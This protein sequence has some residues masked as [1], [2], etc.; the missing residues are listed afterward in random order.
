MISY[1]FGYIVHLPLE[2]NKQVILKNM[3]GVWEQNFFYSFSSSSTFVGKPYT[4]LYYINTTNS[5]LFCCV[6]L[7][8]MHNSSYHLY[9]LPLL[10]KFF[11]LR[12]LP[13]TKVHSLHPL[14]RFLR[15]PM[16]SRCISEGNRRSFFL[17]SILYANGV[18][19]NSFLKVLFKMSTFS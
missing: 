11:F 16:G 2:M 18:N 14:A 4:V 8:W 15:P 9:K 5:A 10:Q 7:E 3:A 1:A 6:L 13:L 19:Y 12:I 17:W